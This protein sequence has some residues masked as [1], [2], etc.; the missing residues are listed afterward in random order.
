VQ[1]PVTATT[2]TRADTSKAQSTPKLVKRLSIPDLKNEAQTDTNSIPKEGQKKSTSSSS[3][4][5]KKS[6]RDEKTENLPRKKSPSNTS[7]V[8]TSTQKSC[9]EFIDPSQ[10]PGAQVASANVATTPKFTANNSPTVSQNLGSASPTGSAPN[11]QEPTQNASPTLLQ[12]PSLSPL[13]QAVP[14]KPSLLIEA[15]LKPVPFIAPQLVFEGQRNDTSPKNVDS[16]N[17]KKKDTHWKRKTISFSTPHT[18]KNQDKRSSRE[19][20]EK[21]TKDKKEKEKKSK[22]KQ[23]K[24]HVTATRDI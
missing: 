7:I 19:K 10:M 6:K 12:K 5:T 23:K 22:E 14:K 2:S 13:N 4:K 24:G 11:S 21:K 15:S 20:K 17:A 18:D 1:V 3:K 8:S 16:E 9:S